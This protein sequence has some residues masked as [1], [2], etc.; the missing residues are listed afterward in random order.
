MATTDSQ[1]AAT[2]QSRCAFAK[3]PSSTSNV[4]DNG[5]LEAGV[6]GAQEENLPFKETP[7][8]RL[9]QMRT[10]CASGFVLSYSSMARRKSR[11]NGKDRKVG[12]SMESWF[13]KKKT[14]DGTNII[15]HEN[16]ETK[17]G[18][19]RGQQDSHKCGSPYTN[20]SSES[21]SVFPT[22]CCHLFLTSTCT[23]SSDLREQR[24][25]FTRHWRTELHRNDAATWSRQGW[26]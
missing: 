11:S 2:K 20:D 10:G 26:S 14:S 3:A 7:C 12:G 17:L 16:V 24:S 1:E 6:Y 21:R 25:L 18:V 15:R 13:S 22:N 23:S 5:D 8:K 9:S 4:D 19:T